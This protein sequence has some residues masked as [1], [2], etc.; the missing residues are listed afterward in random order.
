M[1]LV[2]LNVGNFVTLRLRSENYPL[3]CEEDLALVESQ[4]LVAYL[5]G[6]VTILEAVLPPP[7]GSNHQAVPNPNFVKWKTT[8][9]LLRGWIIGTLSEEAFGI[10]IGLD[11]SAQKDLDTPLNDYLRKFKGVCDNLSAI[12]FPVDDKTKAFSLL[13]GLGARY[14]PFTT[15]MLKPPMPS[16]AEA[17]PLLQSYETRISLHSPDSAAYTAFYGQKNNSKFTNK[18]AR[19]SGNFSSKGKGFFSANQATV[20]RTN[21]GSSDTKGSNEGT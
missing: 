19:Q 8:Y 4:E 9:R 7:E 3:W 2:S 10:V 17:M 16:Y 15:S 6:K 13:N 11:T 14:E 18:G 5:M 12:G 20:K 21:Q 1:S